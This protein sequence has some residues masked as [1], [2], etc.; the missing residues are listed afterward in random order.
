MGDGS[1]AVTTAHLLRAKDLI[2]QAYAGPLDVG[3]LARKV[4]TSPAHFSRAFKRAFGE[5]PYQYLLTRRMERA[6]SMLRGTDRTIT[7]ICLA[8]GFTSLGSFSTTFRRLVGQSPSAYR[9]Q[10]Q[11]GDAWQVVEQIPSCV[12][13]AWTRPRGHTRTSSL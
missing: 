6:K 9:R 2:D 13:M 1:R 11:A 8:V 7:D 12:V 10:W 4:H 3:A 5:T